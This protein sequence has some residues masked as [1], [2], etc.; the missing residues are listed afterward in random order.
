VWRFSVLALV[1][2]GLL[3]AAGT[4]QAVDR[5]VLLQDL[6][7]T[8]YGIALLA[9]I[10]LLGVVLAVAAFNLLRHGPRGDARALRRGTAIEAALLAVV[11][12]ATGTLTALPPPAQASGAAFDQTQHVGD[13]RIELVVPAATPG[14]E[15]F[16]V[17]VQHG[18]TPVSG[19]EKV[20]LRFTM[21]EHDMGESELVATERAP[22]EYVAVGSPTAMYGTWKVRVLVR[23]TGRDDTVALFTVPVVQQAGQG[24]T[25]VALTAGAYS[26]VVFPDP[27]L[28][29]AGAPIALSI[30]ALDAAGAPATGLAVAGALRPAD[31]PSAAPERFAG[32]ELGS[33]RYRIDIAA[34]AKGRWTM[35][36]SLGSATNTAQY[37]FEVAP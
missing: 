23:L 29:V 2:V 34:L 20:A 9:K 35:T 30:V 33:G 18:L 31:A 25:A 5:L 4:L 14:R 6:I 10:A 21:V 11:F 15:R 8:P 1:S 17:R 12:V 37:T 13:E 7:E 24:A 36:L 3:V 27:S 22:G 32:T 26:L 16:V 19:A 28:P